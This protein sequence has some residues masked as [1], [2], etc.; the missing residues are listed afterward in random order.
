[1]IRGESQWLIIIGR[2]ASPACQILYP[3]RLGHWVLRKE[4]SGGGKRTSG[5]AAQEHMLVSVESIN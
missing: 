1:M 4:K 2:S 5:D 3:S